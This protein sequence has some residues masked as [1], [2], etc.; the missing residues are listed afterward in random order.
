MLGKVSSHWSGANLHQ[1]RQPEQ[2]GKQERWFRTLQTRLI[3]HLEGFAD[4]HQGKDKAKKKCIRTPPP[5]A[6]G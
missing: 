1:Q 6:G 2:N 5:K 4:Q 3:S